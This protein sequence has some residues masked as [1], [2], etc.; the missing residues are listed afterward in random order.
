[1]TVRAHRWNTYPAFAY[2]FIAD[3]LPE[4]EIMAGENRVQHVCS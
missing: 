3:E 1:M 4:K 2:R